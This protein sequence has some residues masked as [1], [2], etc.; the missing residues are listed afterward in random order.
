MFRL[1]FLGHAALALADY[2]KFFFS[3]NGTCPGLAWPCVQNSVLAA[4]AYDSIADKHYC[5]GGAAQG[6]CRI[7]NPEC[8]GADGGPSST[9][10]RC[11]AGDS[12]WCCLKDT[13]SCTTRVGKNFGGSCIQARRERSNI[14]CQAKSTCASERSKIQSV[15]S[16]KTYSMRHSLHSPSPHRRA[17]LMLSMRHRFLRAALATSS[18]ATSSSQSSSIV[19]SSAEFS[20]S[21]VSSLPVPTSSSEDSDT[22]PGGTI[23]GIVVGCVVGIAAIVIAG[24][25]AIRRHGRGKN[26][27]EGTVNVSKQLLE[28]QESDNGKWNVSELPEPPVL[29]EIGGGY[30]AHELPNRQKPGELSTN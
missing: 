2:Q 7:N 30:E 8:L 17:R 6:T 12:S 27:T 10:Q 23:A 11:T 29:V 15:V 25:F 18:S 19:T 5:C 9:Q 16:V 21:S 1:A 20:S 14:L 26:P 22:L 28:K 3:A 4:C 24:W 13:E